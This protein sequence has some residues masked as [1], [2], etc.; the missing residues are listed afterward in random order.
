[1][2]IRI[3]SPAPC[4][5][6]PEG[7]RW[8]TCQTSRNAS[9]RE[10]DRGRCQLPTIGVESDFRHSK[11]SAHPD[12]VNPNAQRRFS[13]GRF[14]RNDNFV[15]A[16]GFRLQQRLPMAMAI[17]RR[18]SASRWFWN[19]ARAAKDE[20]SE[21]F[22]PVSGRTVGRCVHPIPQPAKIGKGYLPRSYAIKQ[23][24]PDRSR[25]IRESNLR[26][27]RLFRRSPGSGLYPRRSFDWNRF[28][29]QIAGKRCPD[30]YE[31]RLRL[32]RLF[33]RAQPAPG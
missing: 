14:Y 15:A 32:Q 19:L 6:Q 18:C 29:R 1:M 24:F 26:R 28:P 12:S 23:M 22:I 13:V 3:A 17:S 5:P 25:K 7:A 9:L 33:Q 2:M 8:T 30:S 21:V 20:R 11:D 16:A 31:Q 27:P 10:N 4:G